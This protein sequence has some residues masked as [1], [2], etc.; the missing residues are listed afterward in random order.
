MGFYAH[1]WSGN[2]EFVARVRGMTLPHAWVKTGLMLRTSADPA[3]P[4]VSI[5]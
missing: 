5:V 1:A 2:G 3:A 4:M